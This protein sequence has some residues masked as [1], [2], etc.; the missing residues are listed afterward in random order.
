MKRFSF[1]IV[2]FIPL[3]VL[4]E[5][6]SYLLLTFIPT[7]IRERAHYRRAIDYIHA[8]QKATSAPPQIEAPV[9]NCQQAGQ[10]CVNQKIFS[11][12]FGWF[13]PPHFAFQDQQGVIYRHGKYGERVTRTYY[14]ADLIASYGDSF[15]HC[16]E[17]KDNETWQTFLAHILG[18]NVLNF[19]VAGYGPDQ[20][21]LWYTSHHNIIASVPIV[22]LCIFPENINRIVNV[23]RNFYMYEDPLSLTKPRFVL[24]GGFTLLENPIK[25]ASELKN[26]TSPSFIEQIGLHDYWFQLGQ[27]LPTIQLPYTHALLRWREI[28]A[29]SIKASLCRALPGLV[30]PTFNFDLYSEAEPLTIMCGIVDRFIETA[31][32]RGQYPIIVLMPHTDYVR[33]VLETGGTRTD[34]LISHMKSRNYAFFD[35]VRAIAGLKPSRGQLE[36]WFH[37]HATTEGNRITAGLLVR[38]LHEQAKRDAK[39]KKLLPP[40]ASVKDSV[41]SGKEVVIGR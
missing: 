10:K 18:K 6:C 15:T 3:V 32:K 9:G 33:E 34:P 22:M 37:G 19:G 8:A 1:W 14:A 5:L 29:R 17:V 31:S 30:A 2:A 23:Y 25:D 27:R 16:N 13:Y 11:K 24:L 38:C 20:A 12:E 4:I 21:L 36:K 41:V 39:L 7:R 28:V 26:L 35:L 40:E